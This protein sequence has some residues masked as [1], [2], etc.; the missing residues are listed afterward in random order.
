MALHPDLADV[1]AHL[2]RRG[3][4][5]AVVHGDLV[6]H[7]EVTLPGLRLLAVSPT[8]VE[9]EESIGPVDGWIVGDP[10]IPHW[11]YASYPGGD[12]ERHGATTAPMLA[13]LDRLIDADAASG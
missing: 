11:S 8:V 1:I 10:F 6:D 5:P 13:A 12:D 4:T 2:T 9:Y 7:V 3:L